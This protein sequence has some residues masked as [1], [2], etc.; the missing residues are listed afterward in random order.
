MKHEL[1]KVDFESDSLEPHMDKETVEIHYFKHHKG[2]VDKLNTALEKHEE[3][4]SKTVEELL[5]DLE[6]ISEE[7]RQA[8]INNAGG[9]YNHNFF[10]SILKKDVQFNPESEIGKA[11][12]GKFQT[13]ENFKQEFTNSA[14]TIFGSG[15]AWLVLNNNELE[16]VQT[17]NQ[18]SV[19][20]KNMIP[21]ITIDVW[22]H[23]YYLKYKNLRPDYIEAFFNIVDWEKVNELFIQ[24]KK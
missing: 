16:I 10:W 24:N 7:I 12:I 2:Y 23:S 20:S 5:K 1:I 4:Q 6:S 14:T 21:L 3:L 15:W 22:E 18:D 17:S 9:V 11:I 13:F 8:I 19:I